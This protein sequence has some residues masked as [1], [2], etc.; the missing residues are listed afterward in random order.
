MHFG[1]KIEVTSKVVLRNREDLS[2]V[3][4][5]ELCRYHSSVVS[6]IADKSSFVRTLSGV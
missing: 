6:T 3:Y 1:G 5:P 4:T 2:R